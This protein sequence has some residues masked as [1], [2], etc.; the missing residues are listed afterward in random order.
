MSLPAGLQF[1]RLGWALAGG[2]APGLLRA[3]AARGKEDPTRL[4]ERLG[5]ASAARPDGP[6]L[7]LHAASVG[8][9]QVARL[10]IE[11]LA[12][13]RPE[14]GFLLTTGTVTSARLIAQRPPPRTLHQYVPVDAPR[15]V[16]AFLDHWRPDAGVFLESELWPNL[17]MAAQARGVPLALLNARM[18]ARSADGWRRAGASARRLL[19]AFSVIQAADTRTAAALG[20]LAGRPV[21][22][23][24]NLKLA[25]EAP[26]VVA[27]AHAAVTNAIA[28][29][30]VW[31]AASTH[32]GEEDIIAQ[33]H[34]KLAMAAQ[35]A[36][37]IL[38]PR[39]P[40]RADEIA[41]DLAAQGL[42]CARRSRGETPRRD[43]PVWLWDTL[44]ELSVAYAARPPALVAGSL[45]PGVGGHNPVE[46]AQLG[47]AILIGPH[48][49][50]FEDVF[51]ALVEAGACT[52]VLPPDAD[53]LARAVAGLWGDPTAAQAMAGRAQRLVEAGAGV[54]DAALAALGPVLEPRT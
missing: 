35:D 17:I 34:L 47:A 2:L 15:A 32:P 24:G 38:A 21:A 30:P 5:V 45:A 28:G 4:P 31:L 49:A 23:P 40:D 27:A 43:Q 22:S 44:G 48:V 1:Y 6:L 3:R 29:R 14:L 19:S 37:L 33:A 50:N 9:S 36:L 41:R 10:L 12:Q 39:H 53:A 16:A 11:A 8:E 13:R 54:L 20:A 46:P 25:A 52:V 42:I 26:R 7:W 51:D 18:T